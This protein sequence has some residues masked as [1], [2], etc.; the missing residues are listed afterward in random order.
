MPRFLSHIVLALLVVLQAG[1]WAQG[2]VHPLSGRRYAQP[3]SVAG[4]DWL[5]RAERQQEE[6]PQFAL[7]LMKVAEGSTVADIGAGSGYYAVRLARLVGPKGRVYATDLQQGMLDLMQR[8]IQRDKLTNVEL[9]LG[10][11][12]DPRLP[13]ASVD[14]ALMVDVYHEF[15]Q[16]QAMLRR[17]R[18]ALKPSGRLILLE[19]RGEDAW[20]P[21][22]PEHKM[23]VAQAKL[24]VEAEGFQLT[25]VNSRLPWQHLLVFSRT[26]EPPATLR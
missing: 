24:E 20:I 7:R 26:A 4:A 2:G 14:L 8:R 21:I 23:T 5:D 10:T 12:D 1:V 9:V 18:A 25:S 22:R 17:I 3:M 16:P 11:E 15:S 6:D 13:P 19:Y